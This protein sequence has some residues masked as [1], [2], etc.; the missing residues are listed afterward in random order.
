MIFGG[1]FGVNAAID[2]SSI[3]T[4]IN[5]A[6][7]NAGAINPSYSSYCDHYVVTTRNWKG[8]NG[9]G[10]SFDGD[11]G[12]NGGDNSI[13]GAIIASNN[14]GGGNSSMNTSN[15]GAGVNASFSLV[16]FFDSSINGDSSIITSIKAIIDTSMNT[17]ARGNGG[18][19]S[20]AF[21]ATPAN[22]S[23]SGFAIDTSIKAIIDTSMN[24]LA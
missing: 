12:V 5:P 3:I 13:K 21:N 19:A 16:G 8:D 15:N 10:A 1:A 7:V 18:E 22:A 11:N 17:S 2:D 6:G 14:G 4:S 20:F 9:V 24:T 23:I